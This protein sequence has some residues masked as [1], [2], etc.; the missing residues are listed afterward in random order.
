M[1]VNICNKNGAS[2]ESDFDTALAHYVPEDAILFQSLSFHFIAFSCF[3]HYDLC[4]DAT[5]VQSPDIRLPVQWWPSPRC[6]VGYRTAEGHL[7]LFVQF[8]VILN[9]FTFKNCCFLVV[10]PC[11]LVDESQHFGGTSCLHI[12]VK[13]VSHMWEGRCTHREWRTGSRTTVEL[14]GD[15]DKHSEEEVQREW[16]AG[17]WFW[18]ECQDSGQS[19]Q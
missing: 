11:S 16:L 17:T 8:A 18:E 14:M 5:T 9:N 12:Q 1:S 3:S 15:G 19:S 13:R 10:M 7:H 6:H 4:T 2:C